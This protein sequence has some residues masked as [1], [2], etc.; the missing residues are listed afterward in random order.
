MP[1]AE[2]PALQGAKDYRERYE[3]LTGSFVVAV[4]SLSPRPDAGDPDLAAMST[5]ASVD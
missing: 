5:Q 3:E 2:P 1:T 4:P